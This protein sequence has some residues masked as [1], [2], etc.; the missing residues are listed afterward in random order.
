MLGTLISTTFMN[1]SSSLLY[2]MLL[3]SR[4]HIHREMFSGKCTGNL[5]FDSN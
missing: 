3:V 2:N 4:L 1:S 5:D